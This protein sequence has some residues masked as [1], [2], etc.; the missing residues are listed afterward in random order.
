MERNLCL[1]KDSAGFKTSLLTLFWG[2]TFTHLSIVVWW[3]Y[4]H[5]HQPVFVFLPFAFSRP[6]APRFSSLRPGDPWR[7]ISPLRKS[8][9]F[10]SRWSSPRRTVD[11]ELV[12]PGGPGGGRFRFF[13]GK[14]KQETGRFFVGRKKRCLFLLCFFGALEKFVVF[15][16]TFAFFH[17]R[18]SGLFRVRRHSTETSKL[19]R[20][21]ENS[22]LQLHASWG[23]VSPSKTWLSSV[24]DLSQ[25][26][27]GVAFWRLRTWLPKKI[28]KHPFESL[29]HLSF[30]F[31]SYQACLTDQSTHPVRPLP[32]RPHRVARLGTPGFARLSQ[33]KKNLKKLSPYFSV[34]VCF[35][36]V[37][38]VFSLGFPLGV[39]VPNWKFSLWSC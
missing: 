10:R 26:F 9:S 3:R 7:R 11:E 31:L 5:L 8:S 30:L 24:I 21:H 39:Y 14:T 4:T 38:S 35:L 37:F 32:A 36:F 19:P 23:S 1:W 18:L 17:M 13:K 6:V 16:Q 12:I 15:P 33:L 27:Q 34:F 25:G 29:G 2:I 20:L 22:F 28:K